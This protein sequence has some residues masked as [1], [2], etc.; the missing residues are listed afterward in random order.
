[1]RLADVKWLEEKMRVRLEWS[2]A[3]M[4]RAILVLLDTHS[5]R[6]SPRSKHSD[7]DEEENDLAEIREAVEYITSHFREPLEA[8]GVTLANIQ[9]EVEEI[10]LY[11]CTVEEIVLYA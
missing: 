5:W 8:K 6:P 2:D 10:V 3:K 9:D 4:L 7:T 1:M 11:A